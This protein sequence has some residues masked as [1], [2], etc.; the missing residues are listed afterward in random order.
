MSSEEWV[1]FSA[2]DPSGDERA[3]EVVRQL[4]TLRPEVKV[5]ALGGAR[6]KAVADLF[7]CDLVAH[8]VMGFWEPVK[9]I[10]F[11]HR[12]LKETLHPALEKLKPR[13]TVPVDFFGFNRFVAQAAH[14]AGSAVFYYVSPQVWASR[15][16]RVN[17]LRRVVE[18]MLV[19]F[20]FE[21]EFYRSRGVP[22]HYVGHPLLDQLPEP[23]R[24]KRPSVEPVVGLL[25]GSRASEVRRHLPLL[26]ASAELL[27]RTR[28]WM[29]F[30]LFASPALPQGFYDPW[31]VGG[32]RPFLL[33]M[34]RDEQS[35]WRSGLDLALTCS[36]T[37][38]LE[39]ALLGVPMVVVYK[40]SW[41]TYILARLLIRVR[42]IAM[43]N[44]L[45]GEDLA[46]ELIQG[47]ATPEGVVREALALMD[48]QRAWQ[49]L[50]GKLLGL[51]DLLGGP[52]A[53]GRVA[54][55]ISAR[56]PRVL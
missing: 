27:H 51:K 29:R 41:P 6:L 26:L 54:L 46:P 4:K 28:G 17:F 50:R 38:T 34:V 15:E 10:P 9:K 25:P 1:L 36:G 33:E 2:G 40:T 35:V 32:K 48:D 56:I 42:R 8:S 5:V 31:V 39:N 21:E 7:L 14:R 44:I 43:V 24:E 12:I 37:A 22:V 45:S 49:M 20:P 55:D 47:N 52:G 18:K 16:G 11:F 3:A 19:I 23:A 53:A 30:V 13:V